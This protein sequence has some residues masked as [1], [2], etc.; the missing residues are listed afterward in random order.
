[1]KA[2]ELERKKAIAEGK[3]DDPSVP[4]RLEDAISVVG[5]C[6]DMCSRFERYRRERENN[7]FE[8]ETVCPVVPHII[9][10]FLKEICAD[11]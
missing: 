6:P 7:L 8:W 4:K 3:M 1:V 9:V 2:R 5:T 11:L 10:K